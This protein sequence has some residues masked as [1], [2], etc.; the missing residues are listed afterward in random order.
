MTA[1][2]HGV[3]VAFGVLVYLGLAVCVA[4]AVGLTIR[5]ADRRARDAARLVRPVDEEPPVRRLDQLL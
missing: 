1:A 2:Q 5:E 3:L 4:V